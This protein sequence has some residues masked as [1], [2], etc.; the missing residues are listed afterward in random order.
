[1]VS[2]FRVIVSFIGVSLTS[3]DIT[4]CDTLCI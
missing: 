3:S 1:M 4:T 2:H